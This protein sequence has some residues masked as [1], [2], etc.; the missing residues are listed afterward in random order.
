MKPTSH[1]TIKMP[2]ILPEEAI[3]AMSNG[4]HATA[5]DLIFATAAQVIN[6]T[7]YSVQ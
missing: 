6:F 4:D 2:G 3:Y 1:N 7:S 5:F